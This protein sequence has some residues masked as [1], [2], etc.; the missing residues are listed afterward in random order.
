MLNTKDWRYNSLFMLAALNLTCTMA[1][2][3]YWR[4]LAERMYTSILKEIWETNKQTD[5]QMYVLLG[6][7]SGFVNIKPNCY[8]LQKCRNLHSIFTPFYIYLPLLSL[9]DQMPAFSASK[10]HKDRFVNIQS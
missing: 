10:A 6:R 2:V 9:W 4:G 3:G 7:S 1:A 8:Q 5:Y